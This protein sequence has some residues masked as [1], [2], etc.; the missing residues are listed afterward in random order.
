MPPDLIVPSDIDWSLVKGRDLEECVYW[1]LDALGAKGI[2]W[3]LGGTGGGAADGGRDLECTFHIPQPTGEVV[4]Q[5]WWIE[6]KGRDGTVPAEAIRSS[7]HSVGGRSDV[8]VHLIVTNSQLSNP[9]KGWIADWKRSHARPDVRIW[10]RNDLERLVSQNPIVALR[11]FRDSLTPNGRKEAFSSKF[12]DYLGY[13]DKYMLRSLWAQRAD[14]AWDG[15]AYFAAIVSELANGDLAL[16][17]WATIIPDDEILAVY[18]I[19]LVSSFSLWFRANDGGI[20]TKPIIE[21]LAHLFLQLAVR[22]PEEELA[23]VTERFSEFAEGF[24]SIPQEAR[25]IIIEPI[26][27]TAF[28]EVEEACTADCSR[29]WRINSK[30]SDKE[31]EQYWDRFRAPLP[32]EDS[33]PVQEGTA[34]LFVESNDESCRAGL[35]LNNERRC[36]LLK[37]DDAGKSWKARIACLR[38]VLEHR[39]NASTRNRD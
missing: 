27:A 33:A 20:D 16:R 21:A 19:G 9:T 14:V 6:A 3:R 15:K 11:L 28:H 1:I 2:D 37:I 13:G 32:N 38:P 34:R 23:T 35:S 22:V 17:P 26:F 18:L 29:V 36:P 25:N 10:E 30:S 5:I 24:P 39:I 8:D 12:W 4:S 31:A 7:I